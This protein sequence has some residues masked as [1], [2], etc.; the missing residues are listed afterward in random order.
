M[1]DKMTRVNPKSVERP[2]QSLIAALERALST[3]PRTTI[4]LEI[5]SQTVKNAIRAL[6]RLGVDGESLLRYGLANRAFFPVLMGAMAYVPAT[7]IPIDM[8]SWGREL[9]L[10]PGVAHADDPDADRWLR[11][12][13]VLHRLERWVEHAPMADIL[14][15]RAPDT[16]LAREI[17][18]ASAAAADVRGPYV[19]LIQRT[20]VEALDRWATESLHY[21]YRWQNDLEHGLFSQAALASSG[22]PTVLLNGEIARRAVQPRT[23]E[24]EADEQLFWA[25]QETAVEFLRAKKYVEAA[26]L[27]EFHQKRH[28]DDARTLNNLGFCTIPSSAS[29]ALHWF[30]V[31]A[32]D[33]YASTAINIYNQCCCLEDL[34]RG[35]EALDRAE[36][37]WQRQRQDQPSAGFLWLRENEEWELHADCDPEQALVKL[38]VRVSTSLGRQDR[39]SRWESRGKELEI[40]REQ[41]PTS[42][43]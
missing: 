43:N 27:F 11:T 16:E 4:D 24:L 10:D 6:G 38:A 28:Q 39:A 30:E 2:V 22:P 41:I 8:A 18:L 33:G 34:N 17:R 5:R 7:E 1:A 3:V 40:T 31:A 14:S 12:A 23:E 13:K 35:G 9:D 29:R 42:S 21:E 37:Y 26:A 36:N 32:S 15:L 19:W 20:N 25:L